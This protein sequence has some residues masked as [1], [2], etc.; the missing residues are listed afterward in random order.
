M[1]MLDT[2]WNGGKDYGTKMRRSG[3]NWGLI[4][5]SYANDTQ[6]Y[7]EVLLNDYSSLNHPTY[8][9]RINLWADVV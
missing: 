2:R 6:L 9:D 8:V 7:I 4:L 5:K 1:R 3:F